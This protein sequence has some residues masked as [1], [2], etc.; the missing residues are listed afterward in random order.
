M[1]CLCFFRASTLCKRSKRLSWTRSINSN[2]MSTKEK[3]RVRNRKLTLEI[4]SRF[5]CALLFPFSVFKCS[6]VRPFFFSPFGTFVFLFVRSL[7]FCSSLFVSSFTCLSF[8][9]LLSPVLKT[10]RVFYALLPRSCRTGWRWGRYWNVCY[11]IFQE[12][13]ET[14][15]K[16]VQS[17]TALEMQTKVFCLLLS[18]ICQ[19]VS[20]M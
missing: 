16:L 4:Y 12:L 3:K 2:Q 13:N 1:T 15:K 10:L 8:V 7:F 6:F 11:F 5:D 14:S 17:E 19:P 20:K 18:C 9:F